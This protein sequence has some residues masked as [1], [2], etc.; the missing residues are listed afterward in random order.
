MKNVLNRLLGFRSGT[1]WKKLVAVM[2]YAM[3]LGFLAIGMATPPL[4]PAGAWDTFVVKLSTFVL[5]LWMLSPAIFLSETPLRDKLPF[6]K[7]RIGMRS[8]VGL[9]IVF[10]LIQYLFMATESLHTPEYMDVFTEY[11][12]ASYE[13]FVEAG[14]AG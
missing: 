4:V 14:S 5:F 11:I 8:L 7:E 12:N 9:M 10:V 13:T 1:P 2:Y 6:F 3:C